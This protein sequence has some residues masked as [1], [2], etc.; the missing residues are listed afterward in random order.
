MIDW[1]GPIVDEYYASSEGDRASRSSPPTTG[2]SIPAR[3]ANRCSGRAHILDENGD[4]VPARPG[5][6]R[7]IST[8]AAVNFVYHNDPD[9]TAE[10]RDGHGWVTVG[11]VGY[12][13]EDGYLFLT[14]R[15]T[16]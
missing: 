1:W 14:D 8:W 11:D 13:N 4:E 10:S 3:L 16:T 2:S 7:S 5:G 9:K 15:S 12:L 6:P